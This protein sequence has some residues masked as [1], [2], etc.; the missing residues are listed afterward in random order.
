[1]RSLA[2]NFLHMEGELAGYAGEAGPC[3]GLSLL[4][5]LNK[6]H[7]LTACFEIFSMWSFQLTGH[8]FPKTELTFS[9]DIYFFRSNVV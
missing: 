6:P 4:V 3:M 7:W 8:S 2:V 1:M 9:K 5:T